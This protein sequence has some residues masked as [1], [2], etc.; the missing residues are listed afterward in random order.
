MQTDETSVLGIKAAA[1]T[2]SLLSLYDLIRHLILSVLG[3]SFFSLRLTSAIASLLSVLFF[4]FFSKQLFEMIHN[5][6]TPN[7]RD[8]TKHALITTAVFSTNRI[9]L[10]FAR[11]NHATALQLLLTILTYFWFLKMISSIR[12]EREKTF[13]KLS[14]TTIY[15]TLCGL[16]VGVELNT[17]TSGPL[18]PIVIVV[19]YLTF[20]LLRFLFDKEQRF[21]KFVAVTPYLLII[22]LSALVTALP[23][24]V[25]YFLPGTGGL[26]R[27]AEV[28][29]FQEAG[30][31]KEIL[32]WAL[33]G[34]FKKVIK[35]FYYQ[36]ELTGK[37]NYFGLPVFDYAS[38]WLFLVGIIYLLFVTVETRFNALRR[39][40]GAPFA[41]T[42]GKFSVSVSHLFTLFFLLTALGIPLLAN[43]FTRPSDVP[44]FLRSYPF[45]IPLPIFITLGFMFIWKQV[46]II[47][48]TMILV[49]SYVL[50]FG[51]YTYFNYQVKYLNTR[52][53]L[54]AT[55]AEVLPYGIPYEQMI[56]Q[57]KIYENAYNKYLQAVEQNKDFSKPFCIEQ[58][59]AEEWSIYFGNENSCRPTKHS[60]QMD[61]YG[62]IVKV[63]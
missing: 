13:A 62:D 27:A 56:E 38:W 11:I 48:P 22:A 25:M 39:R 55:S 23:R 61:I 17:Y 10:T 47:R 12:S 46:K 42:Q 31:S 19:S 14:L 49:L 28:S 40:D 32:I 53:W 60:I 63:E 41:V 1:E 43:L 2:N 59:I 21:K 6:V 24:I 33:L 51:P 29:I 15:T 26:D 54:E 45:I 18:I 52:G 3:S 35:M 34:N 36:G 30:Q 44:S 20:L 58:N 9:F 4:Y 50:A 57:K 16:A 37:H 7:V 5:S 8:Y